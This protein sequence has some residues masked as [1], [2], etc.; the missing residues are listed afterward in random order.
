ME[1]FETR[2]KNIVYSWNQRKFYF[3]ESC[4]ECQDH[5]RS[6]KSLP[7]VSKQK[8]MKAN[9]NQRSFQATDLCHTYKV[10]TFLMII[11]SVRKRKRKIANIFLRFLF[12]VRRIL[13]SHRKLWC[14]ICIQ[15]IVNNNDSSFALH[16]LPETPQ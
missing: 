8:Q 15:E 3:Q 13:S 11:L 1:T 16:F 6:C 9:R 5:V 12:D 10:T 14:H 2:Q 4:Q 7:R